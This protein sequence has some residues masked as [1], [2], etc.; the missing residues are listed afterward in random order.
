VSTLPA[1]LA[2]NL[3]LDR[4]LEG[5]LGARPELPV[6]GRAVFVAPHSATANAKDW[7]K[8]AGVADGQ[9]CRHR[10]TRC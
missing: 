4:H 9:T 3:D 10:T 5:D 7:R 1:V 2:S 6:D 8:P